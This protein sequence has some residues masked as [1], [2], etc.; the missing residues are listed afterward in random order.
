MRLDK[1][2]K[3]ARIIKRRTIAKEVC[4]AG[5]VQLNGR[6]A[7]AGAEIAIGDKLKIHYGPRILEIEVAEL[8]ETIAAAQAGTLYTIISEERIKETWPGEED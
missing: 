8:K 7:K 3:V 4:D 6:Q 2:L 1:Y 5:K